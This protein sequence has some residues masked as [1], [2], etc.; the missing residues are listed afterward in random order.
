MKTLQFRGGLPGLISW[1]PGGTKLNIRHW[2]S[3]SYVAALPWLRSI[4]DNPAAKSAAATYATLVNNKYS[5][6][7]G[8]TDTKLYGLPSE[9]FFKMD[10]QLLHESGAIAF[11]KERA[12]DTKT[13]VAK[14]ALKELT[15]GLAGLADGLEKAGL[16]KKP[17]A[18]YAVLQ[19]DGD[20]IGRLLGEHSQ[21]VK[22]GLALFTQKVQALFDPANGNPLMGALV[23]AGGD[24]VLAMLPVDTAIAAACAIRDDYTAAFRQAGASEQELKEFTL[25]GAI[26]YSR[27]NSPLTQ[28]LRQAGNTLDKIAKDK[29]GRNSLALCIMKPGGVAAEWV[30]VFDTSDNGGPKT[31]ERLAR[32]GFS[33]NK[34]DAT[35]SGGFFHGLRDH[36]LDLFAPRIATAEAVESDAAKSFEADMLGDPS[37][38]TALIKADL[39]RQFGSKTFDEAALEMTT[40]DALKILRPN[41][42]DKNGDIRHQLGIAFD[43]GLVV[44]FLAAEQRRSLK[45][46]N[47]PKN[48]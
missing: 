20:N 44:R 33:K 28:V 34:A 21:L 14:A 13:N 23:Y 30:D 26:V 31:L 4:A 25:S 24:D 10:G 42:R 48:D 43:G 15:G 16:P 17:S 8:E 5:G 7:L 39:K 41:C 11:V 22:E 1:K 47:G 45:T 32:D 2:P 37:L 40:G 6:A 12:E 29:N 27:F 36:Y 46:E 9:P 38:L 18:F 19:M 3:T 35:V